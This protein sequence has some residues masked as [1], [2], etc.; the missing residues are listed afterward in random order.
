MNLT[1]APALNLLTRH[2]M[3]TVFGVTVGYQDGRGETGPAAHT[4]RLRLSL[5]LDRERAAPVLSLS[6]LTNLHSITQVAIDPLHGLHNY[7]VF[8][9]ANEL[10]LPRIS[11]HPLSD[12]AQHIY[13][14]LVLC[15][16][17]TITLE[18]LAF[19]PNG[20]LVMLDAAVHIDTSANFRHPDFAISVTAESD[21]ERLARIAG[22]SYLRLD[23]QIG[24][25]ANGAGLA[26][27]TM[28]LLA[29]AGAEYGLRPANFMDIGG[30]ARADAIETG[31]RLLLQY[32]D[33]RAVVLNVFGGLTRGDEV[34]QGVISACGETGPAIP[35]ILR[36]HGTQAQIGRARI[37][38]AGLS[39]IYFASTLTEAVSAAV[40]AARHAR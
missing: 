31:V 8:A 19:E 22:I 6:E 14:I 37:E 40:D 10:E 12:A 33:V 24:C 20:R 30:G 7:Q 4:R 18:P 39:N 13:R 15:D 1:G 11:W 2:R 38:N 16:A 9:L 36:M 5:T 25:I 27:A 26:M 3:P 32:L 35:F 21:D 23:G 28:D 29:T 34:A 17:L